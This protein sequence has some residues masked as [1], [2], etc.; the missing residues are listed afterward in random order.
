[1]HRS[2]SLPNR[3]A[4][5]ASDLDEIGSQETFPYSKTWEHLMQ[6]QRRSVPPLQSGGVGR[7]VSMTDVPR[8]I[9]ELQSFLNSNMVRDRSFESRG[10]SCGSQPMYQPRPM[11]DKM[12]QDLQM[13]GVS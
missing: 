13:L 5:L 12:R 3:L 10:I 9:D 11:T 4:T 6:G 2:T 7:D 8:N 1:M